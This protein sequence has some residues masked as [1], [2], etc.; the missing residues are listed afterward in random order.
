MLASGWATDRLFGGRAPR[1]CVFMMALTAA[2]LVAF[3]IVPSPLLASV[4]FV[5]SGFLLYGPQALT[6]VSATNLATK[7]LAG[8]AIGFISLFS[9]VG[10]S[11][12]GKVCGSLAQS[13][14]GWS[15]PVYAMAGTAATGALFFLALWRTRASSYRS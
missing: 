11:V 9:Y 7:S 8:T 2:A 3:W 12:S 4:A 1:L 6:G 14:G 5:A 13:C 15:V 10:V